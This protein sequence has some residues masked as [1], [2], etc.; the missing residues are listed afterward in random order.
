MNVLKM[1]NSPKVQQ[2][3]TSREL[4]K[5]MNHHPCTVTV[6]HHMQKH[7][8]ARC[9][10]PSLSPVVVGVSLMIPEDDQISVVLS[11]ASPTV[12][13]AQKTKKRSRLAAVLAC[14]QTVNSRPHVCREMK[15]ER[16]LPQYSPP[17]MRRLQ[18]L[19]QY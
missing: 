12:R 11:A 2:L 16:N 7:P 19:T 1:M 14:L 4:L 15:S 17:E 3:P 9:G 6:T 5:A 8:L 18:Q 10:R 13:R